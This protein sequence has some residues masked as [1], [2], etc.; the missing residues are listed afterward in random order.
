MKP[1]KPV[2]SALSVATVSSASKR[3]DLLQVSASS[4]SALD[5][6]CRRRYV[7]SFLDGPS[8]QIPPYEA[9]CCDCCHLSDVCR[10][11]NTAVVTPVPVAASSTQDRK[12]KRSSDDEEENE[13]HSLLVKP[14][15]IE[16]RKAHREVQSII[17]R[18]VQQK[19][20]TTAIFADLVA[21]ERK[22]EAASPT[23]ATT[24]APAKDTH[25]SKG[26]EA[27]RQA[28]QASKIFG[29]RISISEDVEKI[30]NRVFELSKAKS[31]HFYLDLIRQH[32]IK[33]RREDSDKTISN[34][35]D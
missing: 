29:T 21:A 27:L 6:N 8:T 4:T 9:L 25:R 5:R 28:L 22:A 34:L 3:P 1:P 12:R 19:K 11:L 18:G 2:P 13:E 17:S 7:V 16:Q 20:S 31:S 23:T 33:I 15:L 14:D 26:R 30:E 24:L 35:L 10:T 32:V